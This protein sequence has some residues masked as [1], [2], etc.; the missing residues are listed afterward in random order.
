[1][2]VKLSVPK[3]VTI[4]LLC[5]ALSACGWHL[6]GSETVELAVKQVYIVNQSNDGLLES[7]MLQQLARAGVEVTEMS[8]GVPAL[9]LHNARQSRRALT[10]VG[11][12]VEEYELQYTVA[13]DVKRGEELLLT[14]QQVEVKRVYSYDA[15]QVLA[16]DREQKRLY[17]EMRR[18]AVNA[19]LHRLQAIQAAE[20]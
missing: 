16:K 9:T 10:L 3:L 11:G 15:N 6:R 13:F 14:R 8:E 18:D 2:T 5:C 20:Q 1:M 19:L 7:A 4:L 12:N 17:Q